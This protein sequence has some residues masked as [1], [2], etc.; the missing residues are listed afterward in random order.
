MVGRIDL[1][2]G[3]GVDVDVVHSIMSSSIHFI[4]REMICVPAAGLVRSW[5]APWAGAWGG[6]W[7]AASAGGLGLWVFL[8]FEVRRGVSV[9]GL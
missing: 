3:G 4:Q 7:G 9:C 5:G 8:V 6:R 2:Q 1:G